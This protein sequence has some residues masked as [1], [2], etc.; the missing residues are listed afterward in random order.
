MDNAK[1]YLCKADSSILGTLTGIQAQT[2]S[3]KRNATDLWELT[4]D[5]N[6]YID[7]DG[8]LVQSDYY[9]SVD[10]MMR[11]YLDST[12]IQAFFVIDSEPVIKGDGYQ[13]TKTVTAHSIECELCN[14]YLKNFRI[15]CGTPDSQEYLACD[16][17]ADGNKNY[18][19]VN[20]YTGLPYNYIPLVNYDDPQLSLLHLALQGT[21]WRVK[22]GMDIDICQIKKSFETSDSIYSFFMKTV[23]PAA[24]IIFEFDRKHKVV[25]IV[26]AA[27][28]GEDTGVFITMRNLMNSFEVTGTSNDSIVTKLI[29]AGA[30][31]LGIE[32]VNFG[33][34]YILNLDYFMNT[35]NEYG[36]YKFVS[37]ELH[38]KYNRWKD[39]REKDKVTYDNREYTR[40][41]LYIELTKLYNQTLSDISGLKNRVPNDGCMVDYKAYKF[42]EL[43][44]AYMAYNNALLAL[45]T[46]YKNEYGVETIGSAPNYAPTPKDAVNIRDTPYWHDFY[47]YQE[48]VIPQVKEALKMYCKTDENGELVFDGGG[49][50]IE[51]GFGNPDYY[52]NENIVKEIDAYLYEWSLYGLDEL[53]AKKKAWSEAA[54]LLF[55]ECFV[56]NTSVS[57]TSIVYRT[58]DEKGWNSLS[59]EQ[60]QR[61]TSK[62]AFCNKLKQYLDYM[63]PDGN[64]LKTCLPEEERYN[65]LTKTVCKGI[66]RQ[67]NDEI[68]K[69]LK[70]ISEIES[71]QKEYA[72][73]R[74][75]IADSAALESKDNPFFTERDLNVINALIREQEF[76]NENI[77]TTSLDSIVTAVDIQKELYQSAV[78]K[79]YEISQPQYS[80]KTEL[81][82]LFALDAF[83]AYQKP[84]DIGNFI[85][86]GLEIHEELCDN[87]FI[88]LRVIS[89]SHN[90]LYADENLS[91]EFSTMMK[92]LNGISDLAF[93]LDSQSSGS[94]T[95]SS[96]SSS[97]GTFGNNNADVQI[98]NNM[99]NALLSTEMFGTA[100]ND[101]ILDTMKANKGNFNVLASSSGFFNALETGELKVSGNC[102]VDGSIQSGNF[103]VPNNTISGSGSCFNMA[104]GT[105]E[106]YTSN[107]NY[108]KNDGKNL[109][110]QMDNFSVD[111][112]GN[113]KFSGHV[114]G[115]EININNKFIVDEEGNVTSKGTLNVE[116]TGTI[117]GWSFNEN[118]F[119]KQSSNIGDVGGKYIGDDGFSIDNR[120]IIN[121]EG[122]F[123]KNKNYIK[124]N[125]GNSFFNFSKNPY[126]SKNSYDGTTTDIPL[127][128]YFYGYEDFKAEQEFSLFLYVDNIECSIWATNLADAEHITSHAT[129]QYR[130]YKSD[131]KTGN[132]NIPE[133]FK[134]YIDT[135]KVGY[136]TL[137]DITYLSNDLEDNIKSSYP[138]Y[139]ITRIRENII[140]SFSGVYTSLP[141]NANTNHVWNI[142]YEPL[143]MLCIYYAYS[144]DTVSISGYETQYTSLNGYT[145]ISMLFDSASLEFGTSSTTKISTTG[146]KSSYI[147]DN[148]TVSGKP[149]YIGSDGTIG[150]SHS[151]ERF[152]NSVS[153]DL[154]KVS[155]PHG[156][157]DIN[158]VQYK[159]NNNYFSSPYDEGVGK[160]FIG[161]IAED[162]AEKFKDGATFDKNN[163][164]DGWDI[165]YMFPAALKLLQ[166]Q[167][168]E[169]ET[170]KKQL[171]KIQHL[172]RKSTTNNKDSENEALP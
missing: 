103:V 53:E 25:G 37:K 35:Q 50:F 72:R 89:I 79:L 66:I 49:N 64:Y 48:A 14:V 63:A 8:R 56:V 155:D 97:G 90:P 47:A 13:E 29:P 100:V 120:F 157:Y 116:K 62:T 161:F 109:I 129:Y 123:I 148:V 130:F 170:L 160:Y 134:H 80:F 94:S 5:V 67:C 110:I 46:I 107:G 42:D 164:P 172:I 76:N 151:S 69:R 30:D 149:L 98:S 36:D 133:Y 121:D 126:G 156:L 33:R 152:K 87:Q 145:P 171:N 1:I 137:S 165:R 2:C 40:R 22:E 60:K 168:K 15:N 108:I 82:N 4:F 6:R 162:I 91:V 58:P 124:D 93:L 119:Y 52:T 81:D 136:I 104:D 96:S 92:S 144:T 122:I 51:L 34:D 18:Y 113:A 125:I 102:L 105:F 9:D 111:E 70:E 138:E 117:A 115:G 59:A 150:L 139:D 7:K 106:S 43:K 75:E 147:Y 112:N 154:T 166:E 142:N 78:E 23:A 114:D 163:L 32:P 143:K 99:L 83:R 11:L 77:V 68:A 169:I 10:D 141:P 65:S 3:L 27:D 132:S 146:L 128:I 44:T 17:D 57:G 24:S 38:D 28:Y 153:S 101:V 74:T 95:S 118:G 131:I 140:N 167:H 20:P 85:R 84:F 12:D 158:I 159:Y 21:G 39:Y 127:T 41:E 71:K 135:S 31:N 19:N 61:F 16:T 86:V 73:M 26:K 88:K 54:N 55:D 45:I